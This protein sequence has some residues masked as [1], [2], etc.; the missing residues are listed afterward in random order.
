MASPRSAGGGVG[1]GAAAGDEAIWRKLHEAGFDE[2]S[3]RR[4]DKAALISYIS[5]LESESYDYQHNLGLVLLERKELTSKYEQL[6]ASSESADIMH[7]RE[8]ATQQSSLAEAKKRE[9]NLKNNLVIQKEFV[10]NLEKALHDMRVETSEIKVS[11][12]TKLSEVLQ[13]M[14]AAHKKSDEAEE[15]LLLVKSLEAESIRTR[16][17]ALRSLHDIDDRE[18]QLRRYRASC[19][20][21]NET[22]EK[23]INLQRKSLNDTKKV[24]HEKEE[25]L[26]KE[27]AL[28]NQRDE[29]ILERLAHI[30]RLEKRVEEENNI[31]EAE[32]KVLLEEK[33][34]LDLK[35]EALASR[36][37]SLIQKETLL[38][39]RESELLILQET[40]ASKE[41]AEIERLNQEQEI[42]LERRKHEFELEMENKRMSFE[43]AIEVTR[44]AL[45][46]REHALSEQE[47]VFAKRLHDVDLQLAELASKEETLTGRSDELKVEEE[48][49]LLHREAIH[50][51]LQ[52]EREEIEKMKSH[53]EKEKAFFE[54]E[55][56]E[57]IQ[58]RQN[59]A[60]TQ[61]DRDELFTLQMKL[62][63]ELDSL[64]GQHGEI[65][66]DADRLQSEKERFEIEWELIDEKKEELQREAVIIAEERRVITEYLKNESDIIK[67]EKDNLRVQF[68]NNSETL[69]HEHEEF[70]SK[71]QQE[72]ASWL[73]KIQQERQDL[74]RDIDIQRMELLN[75][76][77]T[78]QMEIDSYLREKEEVFEQKRSKELEHI[79]SQKEMIKTKLE[80]VAVE[81]QKLEDERKEATLERERREQELSEINS[82]I[83][84]L[85]NQREKLQEQ[86]KLLHS[87]REAI[88]EQIQQLNVLEELK[89]DSENKQLSLIEHSKPKLG[90]IAKVKDIGLHSQDADHHAS[91]NNCSSQKHL[92]GRKLELSPSLSTPISWVRECAQVIF[93]WSPEKRGDRDRLVQNVVPS[94]LG[95][96]V[97]IE[98]MNF[99][100]ANSGNRSNGVLADQLGNGVGEVPRVVDGA[101]V[102]KKRLNYL[103]SCDQNEIV[104]PRRKQRA[105]DKV[106]GGEIT[107]NCPSALEEKCSKNEHDEAP[108]GLSDTCKEHE[109]GNKGPQ[110]FR[111]PGDPASSDEAATEPSNGDGPEENDDSDDE[112][113]EEEKTSSA[114][115]LWRFLIT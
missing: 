61:E 108:L 69:S 68:K 80:H 50:D 103:V 42:A 79:N 106:Y 101:K 56:W 70:M 39:K 46:E 98:D 115:K 33:N 19:E 40:I 23:E 6:R 94:K 34:K 104:E 12:E 11:Y 53:L 83:E 78:R 113:E 102:G 92:I 38:D 82:T 30:I 41:R 58:A 29:N 10:A 28:L 64:R 87:D 96:S 52:K 59:L 1:G 75:S 89:I 32:Q 9:E 43:T 57:A 13:L 5:R 31:L 90:S 63:E 97:D 86:R 55:K 67:Q 72:H 100:L 54:E 44:T 45:D 25:V 112:G 95:E 17:A 26:L 60:I 7:K 8:R 49:L 81:L 93:K 114:K 62:K 110:N 2:E 36:E 105:I 88:T 15:K 20:L 22:K 4:R 76:A 35:M 85:N 91:P 24:L 27:Q 18:D 73:S 109:Y 51:E 65:M 99:G 111:T 71:M 107:S 21:E 37:E 84:A 48:K 3:V 16:S 77:K 66:A 14:E 47:S 74:T